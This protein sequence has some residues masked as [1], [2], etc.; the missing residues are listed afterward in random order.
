M[1]SEAQEYMEAH[2]IIDPNSRFR[3]RWDILQVVLLA[4]VALC[5]PCKKPVQHYARNS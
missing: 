2:R 1:H 5:V 3:K 4:Y